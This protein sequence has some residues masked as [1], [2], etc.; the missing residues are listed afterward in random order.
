MN[1]KRIIVTDIPIIEFILSI[2]STWWAIVFLNS[3]DLFEEYP[4]TYD[5]FNKLA[6]ITWWA[7][8]FIV[9]AAIKVI[10]ILFHIRWLRR[11]GLFLSAVIY[12]LISYCYLDSVGWFSIGFGTFFAMSVMALW[13]MREVDR[14]NG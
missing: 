11:I 6:P 1:K 14:T 4:Q 10:G 12:G 13:G 5:S 9:A 2:I 7:G 3:P 8:L